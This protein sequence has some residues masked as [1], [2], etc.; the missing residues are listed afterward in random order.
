MAGLGENEVNC[1]P[2]RL[3]NDLQPVL[4]PEKKIVALCEYV[5]QAVTVAGVA[6]FELCDHVLTQKQQQVPCYQQLEDCV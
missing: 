1:L 6:D 3:E 2:F 4:T 5:H